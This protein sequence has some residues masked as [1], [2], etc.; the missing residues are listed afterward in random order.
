MSLLITTTSTLL[1]KLSASAQTLPMA[2]SPGFSL[3]AVFFSL[4]SLPINSLQGRAPFHPKSGPT[5][6]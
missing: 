1:F 5:K 3:Q 2:L 4:S 6:A